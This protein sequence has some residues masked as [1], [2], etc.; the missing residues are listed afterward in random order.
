L[1]ASESGSFRKRFVASGKCESECVQIA[2]EDA[3]AG[4]THV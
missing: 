4:F 2:V 1:L 3:K